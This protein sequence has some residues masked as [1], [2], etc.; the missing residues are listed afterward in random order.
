MPSSQSKALSVHIYSD[1]I[2]YV[3]DEFKDMIEDPP[4]ATSVTS[5]GFKSHSNSM[6]GDGSSHLRAN[7]GSKNVTFHLL[8]GLGR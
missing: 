3:N 7:L 8:S 6:E 5:Y 1:F 2:L 4:K